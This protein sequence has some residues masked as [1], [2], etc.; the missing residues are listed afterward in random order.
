MAVDSQMGLKL[1]DG[2]ALV[3]GCLQ[4]EQQ[5]GRQIG[6][7]AQVADDP[8]AVVFVSFVVEPLPPLDLQAVET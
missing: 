6:E 5:C 4:K 7:K 8:R 1:F 2:G 3:A